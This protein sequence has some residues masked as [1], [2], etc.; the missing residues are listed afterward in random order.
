M[1]LLILI[2]IV[3]S[4]EHF[5]NIIFFVKWKFYQRIRS[6]RVKSKNKRAKQRSILNCKTKRPNKQTHIK[7]I[8][9][10]SPQEENRRGNKL[11][12]VL[13]HVDDRPTINEHGSRRGA[14]SFHRNQ[15]ADATEL[16]RRRNQA[17]E[18]T[19]LRKART[20]KSNLVDQRIGKDINRLQSIL[21]LRL[22]CM[23]RS[24]IF[25]DGDK[26]ED[27]KTINW[28]EESSELQ[29]ERQSDEEE[30]IRRSNGAGEND[31]EE[32][33]ASRRHKPAKPSQTKPR[34]PRVKSQPFFTEG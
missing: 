32:V 1:K 16:R 17:T 31:T 7:Q 33:I 2:N 27:A 9:A 12:H 3:N 34:L 8:V 29:N 6:N 21:Q 5:V 23:W 28:E 10:F 14:A 13:F 18:E 26:L 11:R 15:R 4:I 30:Q 25:D 24:G 22:S 20:D 19:N